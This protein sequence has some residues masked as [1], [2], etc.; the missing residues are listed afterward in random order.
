MR[1]AAALRD[2]FRYRPTYYD[3]GEDTETEQRTNFFEWGP[4]NSRGFRALKVWLALRHA[5]R[6]GYRQMIADDIAAA[7][8]MYAAAVAEPEIEAFACNLSITTFRYVP[9]HLQP[10]ADEPETAR[11][12]NELNAAILRRIQ[13]DGKVFL[14]N[15]VVDGKYLL[16]AC[17][18][19][20]RTTA[21]DAEAVLP[22]VVRIG[23]E[24]TRQREK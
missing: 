1:D 22:E 4:Q 14:S 6:S 10:R 16:R 21:A 9:P 20:F 24:L 23:R 17:I 18:V 3:Y 12:L 11:S 19:N 8:A 7:R 2:T 5:G 13:A 15:A